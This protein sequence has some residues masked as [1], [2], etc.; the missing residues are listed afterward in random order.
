MIY[1]GFHGCFGW[2]HCRQ[3]SKNGDVAILLCPALNHDALNSHHAMRLLADQ[4]AEAG[5]PTMRFDY[6]ATGDSCDLD[7]LAPDFGSEL[8]AVW[9]NSIHKAADL[10][11][12]KT[13]AQKLVFCGLRIGAT[14]AAVAAERRNDVVG[15]IFLAPVLKGQSYLRQIWIESRLQSQTTPPMQDGIR[16]QELNFSPETVKAI[17]SVDLRRIAVPKFAN[18]AIFSQ[19]QTALLDECCQAWEMSG[20]KLFRSNFQG[21]EPM[22]VLNIEDEKAHPR[23][24]LS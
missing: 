4:L 21:L 22:L 10:L 14:L 11:L 12:R 16:F 6:P 19:T 3:D 15:L 17:G 9:L 7:A 5:Y 13:G 2:L 24:D 20:A 8:W 23:F 18:I 1:L